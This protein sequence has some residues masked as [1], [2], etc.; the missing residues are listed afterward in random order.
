MTELMKQKQ[1]SPMRVGEMA[2][3]LFAV[4]RG[5]LDDIALNQISAFESALLSFMNTNKS[6]LMKKINATGDYNDDIEAQLK[7]SL[8][9][10]KANHAW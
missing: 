8:D 3:S 5:Y 9:D 10:F 2:V 7:Q 1:Y 6:D 4:D